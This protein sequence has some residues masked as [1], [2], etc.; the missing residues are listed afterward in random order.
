[1]GV[2]RRVLLLGT[3]V[4]LITATTACGGSDEESAPDEA[5]DGRAVVYVGAVAFSGDRIAVDLARP[6]ADGLQRVRAFV[7]DG[8][9]EGDAEWFEGTATGGRMDMTSVTGKARLSGTAADA[10]LDGTITLADGT[11]RRFH[12]IAATGGAGIYEV[13]VAPNGSFRGVSESGAQLQADPKGVFVEG[14]IT[15][16]QGDRIEYRDAD[17]SRAFGFPV[18]G[19]QPG[20]YTVVVSCDGLTQVGRGGAVNQGAP[21]A[22]VINLGLGVGAGAVNTPGVWYGKVGGG[23]EQFVMALGE[24]DPAGVRSVRVL[25]SDGEPEP[26]GDVEWFAGDATGDAFILTSPTTATMTGQ[27]GPEYVFGQVTLPGSAPRP[28]LAV[29]AADGAG[30][31]DVTVT[32]D[33]QYQ[34]TSEHGGTFTLRQQGDR[35]TG[36]VNTPDGRQLVLAAH[37]LTQ[38]FDY[39]VDGSQPGTYLAIASPGGADLIGRSGD[40]RAGLADVELIG[41]DKA[42]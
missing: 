9:P 32:P 18:P 14:V 27:I 3:V 24:P 42:C 33:K 11:E 19:N 37:D 7:T 6:R 5:P 30:I 4:A 35:V 21:D 20:T 38:V 26:E 12:T 2:L 41:L 22:N 17:L 29:P 25:L 34:G 39:A 10:R 13:T 28:Y 8:T 16:P 36:V 23:T 31:Y 1:M 40:V 15:T